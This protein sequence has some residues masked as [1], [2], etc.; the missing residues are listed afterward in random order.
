MYVYTSYVCRYIYIYISN[1]IKVFKLW[2]DYTIR[3]L[4]ST[5]NHKTLRSFKELESRIFVEQGNTP[6]AATS[7]HMSD[8]S[9]PDLEGVS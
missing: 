5:K 8:L 2:N 9:I 6:E 3:V 1:P 7:L 4:H